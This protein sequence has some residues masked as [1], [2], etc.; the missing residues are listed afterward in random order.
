MDLHAGWETNSRLQDFPHKMIRNV[1]H[2]IKDDAIGE[3][4]IMKSIER[5]IFIEK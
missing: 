1:L 5:E 2:E 4:T 3:R